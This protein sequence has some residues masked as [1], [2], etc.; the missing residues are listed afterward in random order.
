M[1]FIDN[2]SRQAVYEQ[3]ISQTEKLIL[4]GSLPAD[5]PIPSVR[6]LSLDIS[7]NPNTIQKAYSD[8]DR[9]GI[10][11]SSAGKGSF[12]S[13]DAVQILLKEKISNI[14]SI[15]TMANEFA[16]AG[17]KKEDVV[18]AVERG[19]ERAREQMKGFENI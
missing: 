7:V 19:Y 15:E 3:I 8:L 16:V 1:F 18:A 12:V 13:P 4:T 10:I 2:Q 6:S 9:R 14:K 17:V 5:S 11:Y